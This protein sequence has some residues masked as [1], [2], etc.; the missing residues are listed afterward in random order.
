MSEVRSAIAELKVALTNGK[1]GPILDE[2]Q[3]RLVEI[4][5]RLKAIDDD[6]AAGSPRRNA[7]GPIPKVRE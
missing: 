1:G 2:I 4:E 6:I 5:E 7:R 3:S